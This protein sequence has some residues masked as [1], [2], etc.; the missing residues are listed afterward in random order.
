MSNWIAYFGNKTL[1]WDAV[2]GTVNL[3]FRVTDTVTSSVKSIRDI[4]AAPFKAETTG[5]WIKELLK[6]IPRTVGLPIEIAKNISTHMEPYMPGFVAKTIDYA[7]NFKNY[8]LMDKGKTR[9]EGL[10]KF[11]TGIKWKWSNKSKKT[12]DPAPTP[13]ATT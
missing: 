13:P 9:G 4:L 3:P 8:L 5:A 10:K 1:V 7:Y 2:T 6:S 11:R 12:P